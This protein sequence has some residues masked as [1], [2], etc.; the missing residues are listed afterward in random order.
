MVNNEIAER[1]RA[2]YPDAL[3]EVYGEDCSFE[4]HVVSA[5]FADMGLLA[6]QKSILALFKTD[7]QSGALHAL[8]V[9]ARTP[10]E[11]ARDG[12]IQLGS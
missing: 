2:L 11:Q 3:I 1:V 10:T 7:I 4:L 9:A 8:S 12:L 6:R 5:D